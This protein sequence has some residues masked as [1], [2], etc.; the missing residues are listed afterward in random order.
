MDSV[1]V[2]LRFVAVLIDGVIFFVVAFV[3]A[4]LAGGTSS[5]SAAGTHTVGF[6]LGGSG[7]L[8]VAVLSLGY[9]VLCETLFGG[10][11]GKLALGLRVVDQEGDEIGLGAALIRNFLRIVDGLF[12]YLVG[13]IAIWTSSDHQ[14][15]GDRAAHTYVVRRHA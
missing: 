12:F 11:L 8:L 14:R 13:A 4:L 7:L 10:T 15:L 3:L 9:Y 6:H 2:A 5:S 1:G